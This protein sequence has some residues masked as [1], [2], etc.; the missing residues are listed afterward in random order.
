[1]RQNTSAAT[2]GEATTNA[3]L[4]AVT[5]ISLRISCCQYCPSPKETTIRTAALINQAIQDRR[6]VCRAS[7]P[8]NARQIHAASTLSP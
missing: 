3:M 6:R 1:M 2:K 7:R 4:Y 8:A 5:P